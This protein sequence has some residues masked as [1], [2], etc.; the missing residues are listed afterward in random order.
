LAQRLTRRLSGLLL[1]AIAVLAAAAGLVLLSGQAAVVITHGVSMNPVY[2]QGDLVIVARAPSYEVGEIAAYNLPGKGE[3]ALHRIIAG[4]ADA[5]TFKGDN[6]QSIDPLRP[7]GSEL[8]GRAVLHIPQGGL[9]LETLTSL[10]VLGLLAFVLLAGGSA[11]ATTR[12]RRKRRRAALSR[13]ISTRPAQHQL[14]RGLPSSLRISTALAAV[15]AMAGVALGALAW[16]GPLEAP[17]IS[18]VKTG[19]RMDFSYTADVGQSPAY[20]GSVAKSPDP[21]FRKLANTVDVHF[22]YHGEPGTMTVKAEVSAPGGWHSS[23]PLAGPETFTGPDHQGKITLDLKALDAKAQAASAV[24]GLPAGPLAIVLTPEVKTSTGADFQPGLKLNLTPLQLALADGPGTL[25]VTDNATTGQTVMMPRMLG[26]GGM[27]ITAIAARLISAVLLFAAL[28]IGAI[29]V[30]FARRTAPADEAA[31]IRRRYAALLVRVHPMP[32]PQ[33]RP[34][35]DVTTFSTLAKLAERYGLLVLHWAR[36]GV[37]TFIVQ[38]E[39]ITYRYRA[40]AEAAPAQ[41]QQEWVDA[42]RADVEQ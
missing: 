6:N 25:T 24:T 20:D 9:W 30:V 33:G 8:V 7:R 36:S 40:G 11:A 10:P 32:A 3:V 38:D 41:T 28:A 1:I 14:L 4:N 26:L 16:S 27:S 21:V 29:I 19:T 12:H 22:T 39:N 35:I 2:Y 13:H 23:I 37:E 15:F 42:E 31:A 17:S 34:V 5:F 18:Q